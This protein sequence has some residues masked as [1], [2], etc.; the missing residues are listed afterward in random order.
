LNECISIG[1]DPQFTI[2]GFRSDITNTSKGPLLT[3]E[4]DQEDIIDSNA[5]PNELFYFN[6]WCPPNGP[7]SPSDNYPAGCVAVALG[8]I[9]N[10]HQKPQSNFIPQNHPKASLFH[11]TPGWSQVFNWNNIYINSQ[12]QSTNSLPV[13]LRAIGE[14][15]YMNYG[16]SGSGST[17]DKARN[18]L[19]NTYGYTTVT[20]AAHN[21]T[22]LYDILLN[23]ETYMPVFMSGKLIGGEGHAWVCDG[24]E[25]NQTYT[26]F[27]VEYYDNG[28]YFSYGYVPYDPGISSS[29]TYSF[30]MNWGWNDWQGNTNHNGWFANNQ[31]PPNTSTFSYQYTEYRENLYIT[32]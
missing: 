8:Q 24:I 17:V 6:G 27:F 25:F 31:F 30:H 18:A 3:T 1:A 11:P 5:I 22:S 19:K 9:M 15:V 7:Y 21:S 32:P 2:V 29:N 28:S 4:W 20:K 16:P 14:A 10:Y 13:L 23:I 12:N 26:E